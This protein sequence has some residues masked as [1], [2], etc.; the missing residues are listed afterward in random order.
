[1]NPPECVEYFGMM[2]IF[3]LINCPSENSPPTLISYSKL[4]IE[5]FIIILKILLEVC[6]ALRYKFERPGT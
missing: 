1:M 3:S 5:G 6:S 4:Y 2:K